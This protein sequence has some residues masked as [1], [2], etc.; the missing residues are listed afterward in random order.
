MYRGLRGVGAGLVG[1]VAAEGGA[2]AQN[3]VAQVC[4]RWVCDRADTAEGMST[5]DIATCSV[6]DLLRRGAERVLA[7]ASGPSMVNETGG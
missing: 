5:A 2:A 6:G 3:T 7:V 4:Q 1:M